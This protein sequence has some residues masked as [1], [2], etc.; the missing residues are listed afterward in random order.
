MERFRPVILHWDSWN[1]HHIWERHQV[2][3][4]QVEEVFAGVPY[5]LP[6]YRERLLVIGPA[7]DGEVMAVVIGP[8]EI[9]PGVYYVYSARKASRKER[10][11]YEQ[12]R[13]EASSAEPGN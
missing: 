8:S 12:R 7:A 13:P 11:E 4:R 2:T 9:G 10:R 3:P 5:A 6:S 1:I